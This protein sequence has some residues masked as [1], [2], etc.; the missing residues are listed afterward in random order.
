MKLQITHKYDDILDLPHPVPRHRAPM[1]NYDR[2]AQFSPLA[3]LTGYDE[4]L[5][6]TARLTD[7]RIELDEGSRAE[8]D[9]ALR[10]IR[11]RLPRQPEITAT[12]FVCDERKS[13][14]SYVTVTGCARKICD[15]SCRLFLTDGR[16]I[17]LEEVIGLRLTE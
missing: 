5:S 2:A 13:G 11:E 6:E 4:V 1:T 10:E 3:A 12:Y 17:P 15:Y 7:Q 14:G 8:L 16:A 9:E